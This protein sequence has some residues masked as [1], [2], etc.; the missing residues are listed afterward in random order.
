[1]SIVPGLVHRNVRLG[2]G[3]VPQSRNVFPS[4]SVE[5]CLRIAGLRDGNT[6]STTV[7]EML[8]LLANAGAS[9]PA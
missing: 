7:F 9:G 3:V 2:I 6:V 4:L 8:P 5:R 1:M